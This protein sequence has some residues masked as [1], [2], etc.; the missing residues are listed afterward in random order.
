MVA[1]VKID[2]SNGLSEIPPN[3]YQVANMNV[4]CVALQMNN[5]SDA[6]EKIHHQNTRDKSTTFRST[7]TV[8]AEK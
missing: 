2:L 4:I 5:K 6:R 1:K 8:L 7:I 3:L